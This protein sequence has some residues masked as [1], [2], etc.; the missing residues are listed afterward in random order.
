MDH[1]S[2]ILGKLK[3]RWIYWLAARLPPCR[4]ITEMASRSLEERLTLGERLKMHIHFTI[5]VWCTRY[6]AQITF[7]RNESRRTI[8][9]EMDHSVAATVLSNEARERMRHLL[10]T[11]GSGE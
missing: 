10:R 7:M 8:E 11:A 3:M 4:A 6:L 5:C 2:G 1:D 9:D